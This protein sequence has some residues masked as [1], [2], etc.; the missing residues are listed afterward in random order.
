MYTFI[1]STSL[2]YALRFNAATTSELPS[3]LVSVALTTAVPALS[4]L[5]TPPSEPTIIAPLG[6]TLSYDHSIVLVEGT[7][8]KLNEPAILEPLTSLHEISKF[9]FSTVATVLSNLVNL[10]VYLFAGKVLPGL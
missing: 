8:S 7:P 2:L 5:I 9:W 3:S 10:T 4:T 1:S 6:S